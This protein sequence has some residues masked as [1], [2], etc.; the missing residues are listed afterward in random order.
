MA[1][2]VDTSIKLAELSSMTRQEKEERV[3]ALVR[4]A[5]SPTSEQIEAWIKQVND[6]IRSYE[7]RYNMSS[8]DMLQALRTGEG[9]ASNFPDICSWL[10][11]LKTRGQIENKHRCSRPK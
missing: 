3:N 5:V 9:E 4:A 11:L 1:V 6:E 8:E 10:S 2:I 7:S